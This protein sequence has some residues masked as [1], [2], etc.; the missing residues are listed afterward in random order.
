MAGMGAPGS[1]RRV[2]KK[3]ICPDRRSRISENTKRPGTKRKKKKKKKTNE[4]DRK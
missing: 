3:K 2:E 4:T 1:K